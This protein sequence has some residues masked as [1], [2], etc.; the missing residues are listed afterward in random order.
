[1]AQV[2]GNLPSKHKTLGSNSILPERERERK[3]ERQTDVQMTQIHLRFS[4]R[5]VIMPCHVFFPLQS[6]NP[7]KEEELA[8]QVC[9]ILSQGSHWPGASLCT[10][11]LT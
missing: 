7:K 8:P 3:R 11:L 1:V 2:V 5:R 9:P 4:G 6:Q 10:A